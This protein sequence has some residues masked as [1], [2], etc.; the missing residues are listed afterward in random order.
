MKFKLVKIKE[1]GLYSVP[2][3]PGILRTAK[4]YM[5]KSKGK[6]HQVLCMGAVEGKAGDI[7]CLRNL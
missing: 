5:P 3:N 4:L 1:K 7:Q 2:V 6:G